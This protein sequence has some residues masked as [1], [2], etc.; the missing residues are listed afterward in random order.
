[1][2]LLRGFVVSI[3]THPHSHLILLR[4]SPVFSS[5]ST[6]GLMDTSHDS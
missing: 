1:M 4:S 3:V 5:Q 6:G 2:F